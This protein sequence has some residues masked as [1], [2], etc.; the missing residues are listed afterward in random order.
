MNECEL[1]AYHEAGHA[2]FAW[3]LGESVEYA[4]IISDDKGQ[5]ASTLRDEEADLKI[6][7]AGRLAES[8]LERTESFVDPEYDGSIDPED[9][10]PWLTEEALERV[11]AGVKD[12]LRQ[13]WGAVEVFAKALLREGTLAQNETEAIF[14]SLEKPDQQLLLP[15]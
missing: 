9:D 8:I 3:L 7:L 4:I 1:T 5:V 6:G 2:I 15:F 11:A 14:A 10:Y 12:T 13:H